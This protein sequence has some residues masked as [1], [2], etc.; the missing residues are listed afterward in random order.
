[1]SPKL[2]NHLLNKEALHWKYNKVGLKSASNARKI[3]MRESP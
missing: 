1:M 2:E 3:R